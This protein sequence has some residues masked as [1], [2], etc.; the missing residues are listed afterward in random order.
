MKTVLV[1]PR[2]YVQG[3]GVL[4][5]IGTYV[6]ML[7]K[8]PLVLWDSCVKDIVGETVLGSLEAAG[9]E[10]V[11]VLFRGD[12]THEEVARVAD[13]AKREAAD[14]AV[15]IGGGKAL[16]TAKAAAVEAGLKTVTAPTIASNDSPTSAAT[17]W[18]DEDGH[19]TGF[20]CWPFN[21]DIVLVDSQVIANSPVRAFVAGMGDALATWLEAEAARKTRAINLGG[22]RATLA[23]MAIAEL[24]FETLMEYGIEARR[25]VEQKVVTPAVEKVI[26][27]NV[28]LSGL[29]FESGGLATAHMIAN[30][31]PSFPECRNLMHGEKV[32]FGVIS[33]LCL[34]DETDVEQMYAIV[35]FEIAVGLPVTFAELN[36]EGVTPH[37]LGP[38]G[39]ACAA[40]GSLCANHPFDVT[41]DSVIDAM[42]AADA[43]GRLRKQILGLG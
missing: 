10:V 23:A 20:E 42:I 35:D 37:L 30:A 29:G 6:G 32:A 5:E 41:A 9:L 21:P 4:A 38:I 22:G 2:K 8:K 13:I 16:D 25:A 3:R 17:V 7:G 1:A 24:C 34:D 36:L 33:Q 27:A 18:Y 26:E 43:L 31:L 39:D 19:C 14:V 15:G 11:E 12:S 40:E 28:L